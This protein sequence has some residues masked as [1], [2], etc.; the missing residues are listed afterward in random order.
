MHVIVIANW[1]NLFLSFLAGSLQAS[2]SSLV[3][4]YNILVLQWKHCFTTEHTNYVS[5]HW[6]LVFTI[7]SITEQ[8][9]N[10]PDY[11]SQH[12]LLLSTV[13]S[14]HIYCG[15]IIHLITG[16]VI[17]SY[18]TFQIQLSTTLAATQKHMSQLLALLTKRAISSTDDLCL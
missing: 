17:K 12:I 8:P 7:C 6:L 11:H 9:T 18:F 3:T 4:Q 14:K 15:A 1:Y 10:I 2:T 16:P 13:S 5:D